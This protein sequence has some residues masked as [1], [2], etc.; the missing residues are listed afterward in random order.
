MAATVGLYSASINGWHGLDFAFVEH[1][2]FVQNAHGWAGLFRIPHGYPFSLGHEYRP[3][4]YLT[5]WTQVQVTGNHPLAFHLANLVL[6]L[7]NFGLVAFLLRHYFKANV[8]MLASLVFAIH[9]L[10]TEAVANISGRADLLACMFALI[11]WHCDLLRRRNPQKSVQL[12]W[13]TLF[14]LWLAT[15]AKE[16][17]IA[18]LGGMFLADACLASKSL[19]TGSAIRQQGFNWLAIPLAL[20]FRIL[21]RGASVSLKS[22]HF[23]DNPL[24]LAESFLSQ[25]MTATW[26]N[27]KALQLALFPFPQSADYSYN[28]LEIINST[29]DWRFAAGILFWLVLIT[30]LALAFKRRWS[31]TLFVI[32]SFACCYFVVSNYVVIIG[33]IFAERTLYMPMIFVCLGIALSANYLATR[34]S[35]TAQVVGPLILIS[36]AAA[37]WQRNKVWTTSEAFID[38][39]ILTAPRSVRT[40]SRAAQFSFQQRDWDNCLDCVTR[41]AAITLDYHALWNTKGQCLNGAKRHEE[42]ALAFA[43]AIHTGERLPAHVRKAVSV[44]TDVG[45]YAEVREALGLAVDEHRSELPYLDWWVAATLRDDCNLSD[46]MDADISA[47]AAT[48]ALSALIRKLPPWDQMDWIYH[49]ESQATTERHQQVLIMLWRAVNSAPHA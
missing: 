31:K 35:S 30:L 48:A 45:Y 1:N 22:P 7:I 20:G 42:A 24:V 4:T 33:T 14:S 40:W 18:I 36:L 39:Q 11:A 5:F 47:E 21:M 17:G 8:A 27:I 25:F 13:L 44:M 2:E 23:V 10:M 49:I 29:N 12:R 43:Q 6:H 37:T 32:G 3:L 9:P 15:L 26:V 28:H 46:L 34:F 38:Q 16:N 41:G 19:Q